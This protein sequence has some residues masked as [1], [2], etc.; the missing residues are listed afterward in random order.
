LTCQVL[1]VCRQLCGELD[2]LS[3][4]DLADVLRRCCDDVLAC[5]ESRKDLLGLLSDLQSD[6]WWDFA[7]VGQPDQRGI[8]EQAAGAIRIALERLEPGP[9]PRLL[10]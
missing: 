8:F 1:Q 10:L 9:R 7:Q 3:L 6:V 2:L 5:K 4:P